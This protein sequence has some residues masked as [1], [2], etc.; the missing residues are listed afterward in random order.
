M[1]WMEVGIFIFV[2]LALMW[3]LNFTLKKIFK[4][5]QE[6]RSVFSVHHVNDLHR[7]VEGVL[8]WISLAANLIVLYYFII[9]EISI[10]NYISTIV[11]FLFLDYIVKAFF[12]VKYSQNPKQSI[13]TFGELA[14]LALVFA[15]IVQFDVIELLI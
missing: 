2:L 3:I 9:E 13:L 6:K 10:V 15:T 12:E 8:R 14:L 7:K 1:F 4:N 11:L 5:E